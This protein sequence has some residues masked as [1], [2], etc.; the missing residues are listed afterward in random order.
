[1]TAAEA[2]AA[3]LASANGAAS[4]TGLTS[5]EV[6]E[7]VL[8]ARATQALRLGGGRTNA[9]MTDREVRNHVPLDGAALAVLERAI[10]GHG[11]SSRAAGRVVKLART[12]ADLAGDNNVG[13]AEVDEAL[14]FRVIDRGTETTV[15]AA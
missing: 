8:N 13:A 3:E 5:A 12:I 14:S 1:M 6:R 15:H 2:P 4:L 10:D 7:R 9:M 11:L